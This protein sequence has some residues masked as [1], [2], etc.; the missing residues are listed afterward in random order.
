MSEQLFFVHHA[1]KVKIH[2]FVLMSNHFHLLI[3]TPEGNLSNAMLW[4]MR[5]SSRTIIKNSGRINQT[6]GSRYK[7]TLITSSQ[8]Y[9]NVY[10]YVY[11]NP[12][13]A[14]ICD[15]VEE[16]Q[17]STL[18]GLIGL[19]PLLIPVTEDTLLFDDVIK[20]LNWLNSQ[21]K[22]GQLEE[23]K[24]GL[25]KGVF[26]LPSQGLSQKRMEGTSKKKNLEPFFTS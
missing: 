10:K 25:R 14:G 2:A 26:S 20:Q 6:Y 17:Y 24:R 7:G 8:Y 1:Y 4:F 3:S 18:S 5:E 13:T 12:V 15:R 16:Y 22:D 23:T 9:L 11:R 19:C 21:P